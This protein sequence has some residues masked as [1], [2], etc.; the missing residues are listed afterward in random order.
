MARTIESPAEEIVIPDYVVN[1]ATFMGA[2][3]MEASTHNL[4]AFTHA[5]SDEAVIGGNID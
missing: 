5:Y 3:V 2:K 1:L 4:D